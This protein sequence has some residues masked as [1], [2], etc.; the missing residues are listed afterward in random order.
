M[1]IFLYFFGERRCQTQFTSDT[2]MES[3]QFV[4]YYLLCRLWTSFTAYQ[5][6]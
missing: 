4:S 5:R 3:F 1:P 6:L 2:I